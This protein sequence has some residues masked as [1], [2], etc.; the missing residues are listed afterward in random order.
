MSEARALLQEAL[1]AA[2]RR[3]RMPDLP[4][5]EQDALA[6]G[7]DAA[8]AFALE[9]MR[10][11]V[12]AGEPVPA[13]ARALFTRQLAD[14]IRAALAPGSGDPTFQALV[15]RAMEP[16]VE[17][18][19]RLA[20]TTV[21]N[22]R[23]VRSAVDAVAHPG[24]LRGLDDGQLR[25]RLERLHQLATSRSW[26]A[27]PEG[28]EAVGSRL[29]GND[30]GGVGNDVVLQALER[31]QRADAL[32][33][34]AAVQRYRALCEQRGPAAGTEAALASGRA[35]ARTGE[36]A[37]AATVDALQEIAARM[38]AHEPGHRV[39]R[40]LRTP[41]GFPGAVD[42]AKDEWD[43]AI[44]REQGDAAD[45]VLLV[46]VKA[47]PAAATPDFTR[48][49]RGLERLAQAG[50][51]GAWDFPSADGDVRIAAGSLRALLPQGR[52]LPPHVIYACSAPPEPRVQLLSAATRAVLLAEP[53]SVAFA[54]ALARSGG[55]SAE[56]LSGIWK[57]LAAAPRLRSALYQYDTARRVREAML[58]PQ[59]LLAAVRL[60]SSPP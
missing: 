31:L 32:L 51:S 18:Y 7:A 14:L 42:R 46:E 50:R 17:E 15:L 49:A 28:L 35:S 34:S 52:A 21:A 43:A 1:R 38:N 19:V 54:T 36:V 8:I 55:A 58:H 41:R 11:H 60:S 3:F 13:G 25:E 26:S 47:A 24:K 30:G 53:A 16:E 37:E 44:V 27:L 23:V 45:I 10:A 4:S 2:P 20:A 5:Q 12:D 48:L 59:D 22:Q 6:M 40:S 29:R 9:R 33:Q 56:Q 39:V 57:Q